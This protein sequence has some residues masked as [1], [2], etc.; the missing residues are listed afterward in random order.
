[1][2]EWNL[3]STCFQLEDAEPVSY[4]QESGSDLHFELPHPQS[5]SSWLELG[6]SCTCLGLTRSSM[7]CRTRGMLCSVAGHQGHSS[8]VVTFDAM[9]TFMANPY[10]IKSR[11]QPA[12]IERLLDSAFTRRLEKSENATLMRST[13]SSLP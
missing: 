13:Y 11:K 10:Q 7:L 12:T 9:G 1:M 8:R 6:S 2:L 4:D 5:P 3:K